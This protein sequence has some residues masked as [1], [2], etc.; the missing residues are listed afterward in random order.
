MAELENYQGQKQNALRRIDLALQQHPDAGFLAS[1]ALRILAQPQDAQQR[2]PYLQRLASTGSEAERAQAYAVIGET[3]M[4]LK[5]ASAAADALRQSL[6]LQLNANV[7][8]AFV[9]QLVV[10]GRYGE[11]IAYAALVRS[12]FPQAQANALQQQWAAQLQQAQTAITRTISP[13]PNAAKLSAGERQQVENIISQLT[14]QPRLNTLLVMPGRWSGH[15]GRYGGLIRPTEGALLALAQAAVT[16]AKFGN[17]AEAMA[18]C[19]SL[20]E[21][22]L[23]MMTQF[24]IAQTLQARGERDL[25]QH[26][27]QLAAVTLGTNWRSAFPQRSYSSLLDTEIT[28]ANSA[29]MAGIGIDV[30]TY[31][32]MQ[33]QNQRLA[34]HY[35]EYISLKAMQYATLHALEGDSALSAFYQQSHL[36]TSAIFRSASRLKQFDFAAAVWSPTQVTPSD[37]LSA[38]GELLEGKRL[39]ES[40]TITRQQWQLYQQKLAADDYELNN[41]WNP[42]FD[43]DMYWLNQHAN[44]HGRS[45]QA[46]LA[47]EIYAFL[48]GIPQYR[49]KVTRFDTD[50]QMFDD[51]TLAQALSDIQRA[52]EELEESFISDVLWEL[53]LRRRAGD[54][55]RVIARV[56]NRPTFVHWQTQWILREFGVEG[57]APTEADQFINY[58]LSS[59]P[60]VIAT[61]E[62]SGKSARLSEMAYWLTKY[63][64]NA[65][66]LRLLAETNEQIPQMLMLNSHQVA[67][68]ERYDL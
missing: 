65:E 39:R 64:K 58:Y 33:G 40:E 4:G 34:N 51:A 29:W 49:D 22:G 61:L 32:L 68:L 54:I 12:E 20:S 60:S 57:L 66:L 9:Q 38:L 5:Q 13:M 55:L 1:M 7:A 6:E 25:A 37:T 53:Y 28:N 2:I 63:H 48:E 52:P 43:Q 14:A 26:W 23:R 45:G 8:Y 67:L 10:A 62:D 36:P 44:Y 42:D 35:D 31:T 19:Q 24:R 21:R 3:Y 47:Q 56:E 16:Q 59:A 46:S 18:I 17:L 30:T 15:D 41:I 11:A 27:Y 50:E